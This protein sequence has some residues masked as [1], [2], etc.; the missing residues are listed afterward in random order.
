[1]DSLSPM[2]LYMQ[3]KSGTIY[4]RF[5]KPIIGG[6]ERGKEGLIVDSL[7]DKI[8]PL[9]EHNSKAQILMVL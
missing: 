4:I 6:Q 9:D 5:P 3:N 8:S 2:V 1:M 7:W